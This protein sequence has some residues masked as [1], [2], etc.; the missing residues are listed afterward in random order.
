MVQKTIVGRF[1]EPMD[2]GLGEVLGE[3]LLSGDGM[4]DIPQRAQFDDQ[5][6]LLTHYYF[7]RILDSGEGFLSAIC[8]K[9]SL[10]E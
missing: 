1:R 6:F 8:L 3:P 9:K 10:V 5:K 4:D 7:E 2:L